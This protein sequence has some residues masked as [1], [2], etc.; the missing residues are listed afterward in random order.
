M[1]HIGIE[2]KCWRAEIPKSRSLACDS[3]M[4]PT[5]VVISLA[6]AKDPL[7]NVGLGDA[8]VRIV[9]AVTTLSALHQIHRGLEDT[10]SAKTQTTGPS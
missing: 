6:L 8:H 2:P 7:S 10:I 5:G 4:V 3:S 9:A 1:D